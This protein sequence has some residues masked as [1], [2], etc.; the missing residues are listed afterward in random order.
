MSWNWETWRGIGAGVMCDRGFNIISKTDGPNFSLVATESL[1]GMGCSCCNSCCIN[2]YNVLLGEMEAG[3][4]T[5]AGGGRG[6]KHKITFTS[7]V[8]DP[9]SR[10]LILS[11]AVTV[12]RLI[13]II[14]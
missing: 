4:I 11:A 8:T 5:C 14:Y 3:T 2:H 10:A 7:E 13:N 1:A 6:D 9:K 12:V